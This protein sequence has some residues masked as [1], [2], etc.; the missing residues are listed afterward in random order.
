ML[1]NILKIVFLGLV[2]FGLLVYLTAEKPQTIKVDKKE[3]SYLDIKK[4]PSFLEIVGQDSFIPTSKLF[5]K[6]S[7]TLMIVGNH[8][9]LSIVK[10]LK[11]YYE[12]NLPYVIVAN[13]SNA[14]WFIK[15]WAIPGK[16]EELNKGNTTPIIYDYDG[17]VVKALN[18]FD[19]TKTKY[20]AYLVDESGKIA[21]VYEGSVKENAM[22]GTMS[23]SE[24]VESLRTLVSLIN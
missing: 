2:G 19:T 18:Q 5:P 9:S 16:L 1:K 7:K 21:K 13:I 17:E 20:F 11:K 15:K 4:F 8:D 22:E 6:D 12:I 14:P 24:K 23:E 10:D 3:V